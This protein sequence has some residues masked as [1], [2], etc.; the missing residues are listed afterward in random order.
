MT[1]DNNASPFGLSWN[2]P[3]KI[4]DISLSKSACENCDVYYYETGS[5]ELTQFEGTITHSNQPVP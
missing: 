2:T 1:A 5:T 3:L 4:N